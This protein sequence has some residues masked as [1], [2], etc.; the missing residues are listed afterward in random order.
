[1]ANQTID[2]TAINQTINEPDKRVVK[3]YTTMFSKGYIVHLDEN[4]DDDR[5]IEVVTYIDGKKTDI[6]SLPCKESIRLITILEREGYTF[7]YDLD[8]A[9]KS[10]EDA[11]DQ[12][13]IAKEQLEI[14][15]MGYEICCSRPLIKAE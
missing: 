7:A 11:V 12:L 3:Q 10:L 4:Y 14:A 1:M 5:I 15:K 9:R 8:M 2:C 6:I 13:E